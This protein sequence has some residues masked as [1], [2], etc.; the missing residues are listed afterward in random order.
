MPSLIVSPVTATLG[1]T[2]ESSKLNKR[3][4][5]YINNST[6][7]ATPKTVPTP[8]TAVITPCDNLL[9]FSSSFAFNSS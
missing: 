8:I 9:G 1:V 4:G 3:D 5:I 7:R 6:A 2:A